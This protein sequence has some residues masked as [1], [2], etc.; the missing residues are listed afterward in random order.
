MFTV[1]IHTLDPDVLS[2]FA[3]TFAELAT[4]GKLPAQEMTGAQYI[5]TV[6]APDTG[7]DLAR[8]PAAVFTAGTIDNTPAPRSAAAVFNTGLTV[9]AAQTGTIAV[10]QQITG[11]FPGTIIAINDAALT[12]VMTAAAVTTYAEYRKLGWTDAQLIEH[13]LM[14]PPLPPAPRAP[15]APL[16]PASAAAVFDASNTP[17]A[18]GAATGSPPPNSGQ[19]VASTAV[20]PPPAPP[21]TGAPALLDAAGMPWDA[22]IHASTRTTTQKGIWKAKK[23]TDPATIAQVTAEIMQRSAASAP[24]PFTPLNVA[25]PVS[26]PPTGVP[27]L[28][29]PSVPGAATASPSNLAPP[30]PPP[31]ASAPVTDFVSLSRYV[32]NRT[33]TL[34]NLAPAQVI[35][36]CEKYGLQG[37]GMVHSSPH[38]IPQIHADLEAIK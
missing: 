27:A 14:A 21:N 19:A 4:V 16:P 35:A 37:L 32:T 15:D 18:A 2:A 31:G 23:G 13:G 22:R 12:P 11:D 3:R 7:T 28:P 17:N 36:A 6:D 33:T 29:P 38:L 24:A 5:K 20:A 25:P 26:M 30:P 9:T 10:G 1:Q 8:T 34:R